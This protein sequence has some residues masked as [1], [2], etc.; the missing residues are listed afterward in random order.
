MDPFL[1]DYHL[2]QDPCQPGVVNPCVDTGG[3]TAFNL[4]MHTCWT[5][6]DSIPDTGIVDMG[7]H[8]GPFSIP[9]LHTDI[10]QI[11]ESTGGIANLT[12]M[13][14]A[15]NSNRNFIMLGGVTGYSPGFLLPKGKA[16][17]P[18]NWDIFT[19]V[20]VDWLNSQIFQNFYGALDFNGKS[21]AVFDTMNPIPGALGLTINFAYAC[22]KP[23]DFASNPVTIEIVP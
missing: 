17:F 13:A 4:C 18:I 6:T 10:Y 9:S 5:R 15:I 8:Y 20:V 21:I 3:N 2:Q 1:R 22:N 23:W 11:S 19:Y 16:I 12:L 14:T 7:Y